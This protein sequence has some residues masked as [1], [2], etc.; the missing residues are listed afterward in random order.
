MR[1]NS[2][3]AAS[4]KG[5]T[6]PGLAPWAI[7]EA[8]EVERFEALEVGAAWLVCDA[9]NLNGDLCAG[10][11]A[12]EHEGRVGPRAQVGGLV[13]ELEGVEE[14][15]EGVAHDDLHERGLGRA[16]ARHRCHGGVPLGA[17]GAEELGACH[18]RPARARGARSFSKQRNKPL[19]N[20]TC[21]TSS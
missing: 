21:P 17:H 11:D 10:V 9:L 7:D 12:A 5:A 1:P 15:F 19:R 4:S 6:R 2:K 14:D 8:L 20:R 18:A 16:R 3:A 13:R